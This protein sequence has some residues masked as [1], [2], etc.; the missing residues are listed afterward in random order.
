MNVHIKNTGRP[1]IND[2]MLHLKIEKQ[3]ELYPKPAEG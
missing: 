2:L 1:Q 3:E